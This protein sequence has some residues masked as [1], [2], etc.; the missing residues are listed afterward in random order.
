MTAEPTFTL[1]TALWLW[2]AEPPAKGAWHF[3]TID[4]AAADA[5]RAL[6][7]ERRALG[8]ARGFGAVRLR[9]AVD[10]VGFE[11]SAFPQSSGEGYVL[12]VKAEVRRKAGIEAGDRV[13]LEL[14]V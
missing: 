4:G 7:F 3:A 10:G 6:A 2:R 12:P 13:T 8:G 14:W 9:A 1:E 5:L 11:T